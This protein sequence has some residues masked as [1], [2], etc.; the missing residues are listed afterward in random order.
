MQTIGADTVI[1]KSSSIRTASAD[2]DSGI[3]GEWLSWT[4]A[5]PPVQYRSDNSF[6]PLPGNAASGTSGFPIL[7]VDIVADLGF[8]RFLA[9][10]I[11]PRGRRPQPRRVMNSLR[12]GRK[13]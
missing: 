8:V 6:F 9:E 3:V 2:L 12:V 11:S 5:G 1:G 10:S 7:L 4:L 13:M